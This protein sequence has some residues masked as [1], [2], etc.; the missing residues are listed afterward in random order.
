[1]PFGQEA[2]SEG[3]ADGVYIHG[4]FMEGARFDREEMLMAESVGVGF[5]ISQELCAANWNLRTTQE[6]WRRK[7]VW[8]I[9]FNRA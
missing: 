9:R 7:N 1:M 5:S 8:L 3:P 2:V 4:L 6:S